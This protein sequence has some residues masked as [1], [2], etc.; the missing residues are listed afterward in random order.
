MDKQSRKQEALALLE[1]LDKGEELTTEQSYRLT[2]IT[3]EQGY[4]SIA[5]LPDQ[6][7][8]FREHH[9]WYHISAEHCRHLPLPEHWF[10]S[11]RTPVFPRAEIFDADT[12]RVAC[13]YASSLP[14]A[15]LKA[16]WTLQK[17]D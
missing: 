13:E 6:L 9:Q 4:P 14:I 5:A 10:W 1:K 12:S 2:F 8:K 7:A 15:M 16:W 17:E 3:I 11:L